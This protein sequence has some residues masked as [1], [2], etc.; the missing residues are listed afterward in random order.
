M[1]VSASHSPINNKSDRGEDQ[2][3]GDAR[4]FVASH[5][6]FSHLM[7]LDSKKNTLSE[8]NNANHSKTLLR[9]I[10]V[11]AKDSSAQQLG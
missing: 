4:S 3:V 6:L 11:A 9:G 10:Q 5:L 8:L 2:Q 1:Q 7:C